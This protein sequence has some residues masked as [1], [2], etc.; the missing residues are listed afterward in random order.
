M[1]PEQVKG[2][3]R[4]AF[5]IGRR[6]RIVMW[7]GGAGGTVASEVIEVSTPR[8][9]RSA[10]PSRSAATRKP[11]SDLAGESRGDAEGGAA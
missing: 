2:L 9:G 4:R 8:D 11:R 7:F 5:I 10:A 1:P 3:F 6:F